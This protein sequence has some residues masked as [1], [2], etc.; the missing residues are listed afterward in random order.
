M[1]LHH[2]GLAVSLA[3][4]SDARSALQ[5]V[6]QPQDPTIF[7]LPL[8]A[9][10]LWVRTTGREE[11]WQSVVKYCMWAT[12]VGAE[13]GRENP[14]P[15]PCYQHRAQCRT[16]SHDPQIVTWAE[17]KSRTLNWLSHPGTPHIAFLKYMYISCNLSW[18]ITHGEAD[19]LGW[20]LRFELLVQEPV[21]KSD[22]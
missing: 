15:P 5:S 17:I 1:S 16:R 18:D 9:Y 8:K 4:P 2:A 7:K 13:G 14:K 21:E 10:C 11:C 6:R 3:L 20:Y 12:G 19:W 22:T